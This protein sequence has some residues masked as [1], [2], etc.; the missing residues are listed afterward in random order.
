MQIL[1]NNL[2]YKFSFCKQF[3]NDDRYVRYIFKQLNIK[4]MYNNP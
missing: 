4:I 2:F 1:F 3:S